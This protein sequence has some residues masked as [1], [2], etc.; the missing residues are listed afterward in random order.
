MQKTFDNR[1]T[2]V[3]NSK[4]KT[5]WTAKTK[6]YKPAAE[7]ETAMKKFITLIM[8]AVL[9]IAC[10]FGLTACGNKTVKVLAE[11]EL[12]AESY[13]FA[14][15]K[16]N[17]SL[18]NTVDGL[19]NEMTA[20]GELEKVI[21]SFFDGSATFEYENPVA[22]KPTDHETYFIVATNAYFPP[23][24]YYNGNKLTGIDMK[25]A[26]LIAEKLNKTLYILDEEFGSLISSVQTGEADIAM[27]GMTVTETRK[28]QVDFSVEY[29][30]SAQVLMVLESDKT[31]AD[32]KSAADIEDVLS[33]QDKKFIVGT[34]NGTTGYMYSAGDEDFGYDGFKN[35]TTNQYKTGALAAKDLQNGKI[36]A[37]IIDKQPAIM[38]A[39]NLNG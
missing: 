17:T 7:G 8:T 13:A 29:Y 38:I 23:F 18:K 37:V 33:K 35:L 25:I 1:K 14:I 11:Y 3:Y 9:G 19:L 39:D 27:A 16:G 15:K 28:E 36:N 34:Q 21:N 31:F 10:V 4:R 12:T 2:K 30:K 22:T 24:E 6:K 26:S 5:K 20:N 32:C